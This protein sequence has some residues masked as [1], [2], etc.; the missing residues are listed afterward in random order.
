M[1]RSSWGER[2]LDEINIY[3]S[4]SSKVSMKQEILK[5]KRRLENLEGFFYFVVFVAFFGA[6]TALLSPL[7]TKNI[8][9][10]TTFLVVLM[11]LAFSFWMTLWYYLKVS[12]RAAIEIESS[13][14]FKK[15]KISIYSLALFPLVVG[16]L[17]L[18]F[19][20]ILNIAKLVWENVIELGALSAVLTVLYGVIR[21]FVSLFKKSKN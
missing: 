10:E 6:L 5:I 20:F 13:K 19:P 14:S 2:F 18:I 12:M 4:E 17:S 9:W 15:N 21:G 1:K 16:L 8:Y 3:K 11:Y 7:S